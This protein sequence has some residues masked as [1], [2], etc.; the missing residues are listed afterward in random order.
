MRRWWLVLTTLVTLVAT[1][2]CGSDISTQKKRDNLRSRES[3]EQG[4]LSQQIESNRD[5]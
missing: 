3:R 5:E 2:A 4:G 1:T